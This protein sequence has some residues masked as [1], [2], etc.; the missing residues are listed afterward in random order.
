MFVIA[1]FKRKISYE[2]KIFQLVMKLP[3]RT[4]R[5]GEKVIHNDQSKTNS[6]RSST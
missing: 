4:T 5:V 6:Q 3:K 2:E 1:K